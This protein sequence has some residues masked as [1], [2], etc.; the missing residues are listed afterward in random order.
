MVKSEK[1]MHQNAS[2]AEEGRKML[3]WAEMHMPV[4]MNIR[5]KYSDSRPLAGKR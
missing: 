1:I 4:L 2:L 5:R 3:A